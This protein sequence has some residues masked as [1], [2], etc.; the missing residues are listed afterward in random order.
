VDGN[1]FLSRRGVHARTPHAF[2]LS[3]RACLYIFLFMLA[4]PMPFSS[5]KSS[6]LG[7]SPCCM[8][9]YTR[10]TGAHG[11]AS[12]EILHP[13]FGRCFSNSLVRRMTCLKTVGRYLLLH[14]PLYPAAERRQELELLNAANPLGRIH[15]L[16]LSKN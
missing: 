2:G 3:P 14:L 6:L 10:W 8:G 11:L 13:L 7:F 1:L 15:C 16:E 9:E 4:R 12:L 5:R